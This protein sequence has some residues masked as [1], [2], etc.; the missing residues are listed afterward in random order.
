ML[1]EAAMLGLVTFQ[2]WRRLFGFTEVPL[3]PKDTVRK[4]GTRR[5]MSNRKRRTWRHEK[6]EEKKS[7]AESIRTEEQT[8]RER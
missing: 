8:Q 4:R 6:G 2:S 3:G 7:N 5:D 1:S